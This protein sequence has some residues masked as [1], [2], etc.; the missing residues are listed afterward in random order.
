MNA[1]EA[2]RIL[3]LRKD[4]GEPVDL[5]ISVLSKLTIDDVP[6]GASFQVGTMKDG[7]LHLDWS[8]T[9]YRAGD[10]IVGE[11]D[12]TWTRKYWYSPLGL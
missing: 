12:Y 5:P 6:D 1:A 11:T 2:R 10:S 3:A 4:E 8:G 9:L 7:V